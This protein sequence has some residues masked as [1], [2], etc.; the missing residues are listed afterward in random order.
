MSAKLSREEFRRQKDLDA[1]RKAGTAAPAVD[2][3]GQAINPHIPEFMSKAP[4]YLVQTEGPS[5]KHQKMLARG[6][7]R[8]PGKLKSRYERGERAVSTTNRAR[9]LARTNETNAHPTLRSIPQAPAA[10]KFRKGACENCGAMTHKK[11]DC[12]ER[13]RKVGAR[14]TGKNIA[15]DEIIHNDRVGLNGLEGQ[16]DF[17]AKRDRWD[18]YDP[19]S[20][21]AVVEEHEAL[22][23]AR[24]KLREE[25]I[26]KGSAAVDDKAVKKAARAG[27]GNKKKQDDDDDF[28]SSDE[29]EAD[30]GE[31]DDEDKYAEGADV[32]GQKVDTKTRITV[33]NLR[34]REDTAK[35][36]MNLDIDSA[37]YDPKTRSMREAP[38]AGV[39]PEDAVFAGDN[40]ARH[41]GGAM[42]VQK[43]QLFA[44]QSES[45]GNDVHLNSNPTQSAL[46][47]KE[48][49]EKKDKLKETSA[50]SILERYGGEEH[51]ERAPKELLGGQTENYVEYSRTGQVIK[52]R[53]RAKAK[54]KYDEDVYPG[55]HT[56]I[57][58]SWYNTLTGQW[59]FACCHSSVKN[60]YCSG[61]ASIEAAKAEATGGLGLLSAKA[62]SNA[63]PTKTLMQIK[64][65]KYKEEKDKLKAAGGTKRKAG[66]E[67]TDGGDRKK[68]LGGVTEEEME[69]YRKSRRQDFDPTADFSREEVLPM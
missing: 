32:A 63:A 50:A 49:I 42:D 52:G 40:F 4:W 11:K 61:Q 54:S 17:D 9:S 67:A 47:H 69:A 6:N 48:F 12:L 38:I 3:D 36:L 34:I 13:P 8:D 2:E 56:S 43:L 59:G 26:D 66:E 31:G 28:G 64:A 30:N 60:S 39:R 37:Y 1:A 46:V 35:Y 57:W 45:R 20:H 58:G 55:N 68:H 7:D 44:W 21:R 24:R 18:G 16:G 15:A 65:D 41:S 10:N 25:A 5:L 53:E 23:E 27:K 29:S 14:Y 51:L 62:S 33:R 22:E 19:A